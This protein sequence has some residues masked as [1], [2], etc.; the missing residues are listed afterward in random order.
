MYVTV[1]VE[2]NNRA[3]EQGVL[4][5]EGTRPTRCVCDAVAEA[6]ISRR[7]AAPPVPIPLAA[8]ENVTSSFLFLFPFLGF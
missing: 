6:S 2:M 1:N 4:E 3:R 7:V 5:R 8:S